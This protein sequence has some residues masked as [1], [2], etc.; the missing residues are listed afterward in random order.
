MKLD[1]E[2]ISTEVVIVGSGAAGL[3]AA[4][5][6][7][8]MG[9]EVTVISKGPIGLGNC[10]VMSG[11]VLSAPING[12]KFEDHLHRTL[13]TGR[14]LNNRDLVNAIC[15]DGPERIFELMDWGLN[16][17]IGK[18]ICSVIGKPPV[19]GKGIVDILLSKALSLGVDMM[20]GILA[21]EILHG[22]GMIDGLLGYD[23]NRDRFLFFSCGAIILATGGACATYLIH[24]NPRRMM[25]DGYALALRAGARLMDMEFIQFYP[26]GVVEDGKS[27]FLLPAILADWGKIFNDLGEE[28]L[29]KYGIHDHP[30]A[31]RARDR[32]SQAIWMETEGRPGGKVYL[33]VSSIADEKWK[34]DRFAFNTREYLIKRYCADKRP[35]PIRPMAHHTMG[36]IFIGPNGSTSV[37]GLFAAGEAAGGVHGAN[38]LGGNALTEALVFGRRAGLSTVQF[39]MEEGKRDVKKENLKHSIA[40][41][42]KYRDRNR[43]LHP[44]EFRNRLRLLMWKYAGVIR[45]QDG[46]ERA[47]D[48]LKELKDQ[49]MR[50]CRA[51]DSRE[52]MELWELLGAIQTAEVIIEAS[53]LRTESRG[54]HFRKDYPFQDD[55]SWKRHI[56]FEWKGEGEKLH[57]Q[58]I[59]V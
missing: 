21:I 8:G 29:E 34:K 20:G 50:E 40:N 43:G 14:G 35:I 11:G 57:T 13:E 2:E 3:R 7:K 49:I 18:G 37:Y 17:E 22:N 4:I 1:W 59:D 25:G 46:L 12:L 51:R 15:Q 36:G 10:S 47:R 28:I 39:L 6:V 5:E 30:V 58:L 48:S 26:L 33:D 9:N 45:S 19:W 54:S 32:L 41:L 53:I 27:P 42:I 31:V 23:W 38:R 24:D 44:G 52:L 16:A 55:I 56:V